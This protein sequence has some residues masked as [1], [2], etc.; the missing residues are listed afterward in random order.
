[1]CGGDS[2][3]LFNVLHLVRLI[4]LLVLYIF[5]LDFLKT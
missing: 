3:E 4:L 1:M 5:S 2:G